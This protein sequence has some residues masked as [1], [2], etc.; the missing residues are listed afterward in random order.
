MKDRRFVDIVHNVQMVPKTRR[1]HNAYHQ[2]YHFLYFVII[3]KQS[4]NTKKHQNYSKIF[5]KH[6]KY[7]QKCLYFSFLW[8]KINVRPGGLLGKGGGALE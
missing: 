1:A 3:I 5:K 4:K 8:F 6:Q 7:T 2:I